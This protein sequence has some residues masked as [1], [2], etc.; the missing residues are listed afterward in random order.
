GCGSSS[1]GGGAAG[2]GDNCAQACAK[3]D[4]LHCAMDTPGDCA[5]QCSMSPPACKSQLDAL[6]ACAATST[7]MCDADGEAQVVGCDSQ[8]VA[9][10][11]CILGGLGDGGLTIGGDN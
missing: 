9:Y 11:T 6:S 4:A 1:N 10:I 7:Y 8:G 2:G 3:A 5:K